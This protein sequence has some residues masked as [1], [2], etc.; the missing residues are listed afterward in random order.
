[1]RQKGFRDVTPDD[2]KYTDEHEWVASP[3]GN[4]VRVGIT[5]YAQDQLGDVVFVELPKVG[6]AVE[7]GTPLGEV[8]STK[9]VSEIFA[10]VSGEVTAVNSD[11]EDNPELINSEPYQGGW[12]VEIKLGDEAELEDLLDADDYRKTTEAD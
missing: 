11:L 12:L 5:A 7:A 2:L 3:T 6:A 9:S 10:P 4:T 8:E 1:V